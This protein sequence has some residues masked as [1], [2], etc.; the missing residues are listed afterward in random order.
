MYFIRTSMSTQDEPK[1]RMAD[2]FDIANDQ[3]D[4]RHPRPSGRGLQ[5][6]SRRDRG[7]G[8][9]AQSWAVTLLGDHGPVRQARL[10]TR[11]ASSR[12]GAQHRGAL[13]AAAGSHTRPVLG[14]RPAGDP[15]HAAA[16]PAESAP[17]ILPVLCPRVQARPDGRESQ[18]WF[19]RC[20]FG[21]CVSAGAEGGSNRTDGISL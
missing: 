11:S 3:P 9:S 1:K 13:A 18:V 21:P 5:R 7:S 10:S 14:G 12:G 6:A 19:C 17:R 4:Y 16:N 8:G 15:N 20:S 2:C